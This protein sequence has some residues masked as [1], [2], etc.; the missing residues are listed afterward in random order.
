MAS[1]RLSPRNPI[2]PV[3]TQ[4]GCI[5]KSVFETHKQITFLSEAVLKYMGY[6]TVKAYRLK[7]QQKKKNYTKKKKREI[8]KNE[9]SAFAG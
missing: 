5:T 7:R 8:K 4:S 6:K 3:F 1:C 9:N 2:F